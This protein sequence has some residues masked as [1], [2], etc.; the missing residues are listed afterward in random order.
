MILPGAASVT[1]RDK[2]PQEVINLAR[3]AGLS[4]IEWGGDI[5]VPSGE[6]KQAAKIGNLTRVSGLQVSAY[7]SYYVVGKS[8]EEGIRFIDVLTTAKM[9][10]APMIRIWAGNKSS[11]N[12][13]QS[14]RRKILDETRAIADE[15]GRQDLVLAFEFH[16]DTL[17]DTYE[18]CCELLTDLAHPMVKTYWQ[19]MHG[20]GPEIN[21]NGIDLILPWI[22][23]VHV[24]HWWP[25]AEVRLPLQE[26]INHWKTYIH[27]LSSIATAI[28]GN[29]EFVKDDAPEQ[30]LKDAG[31][32]L[33]LTG[34]DLEQRRGKD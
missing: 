2:T 3:Q 27:K 6:L 18:S 15:A 29:L 5:H 30:F 11:R 33:E 19:P 22:V 34:Y 31:T 8:K 10:G 24:F 23:G 17:N 14:Y 1:F 12:A 13:S 4:G 21:G 9:L 16:D 32:L 7:G 25:K 28:P 26:G 20:V